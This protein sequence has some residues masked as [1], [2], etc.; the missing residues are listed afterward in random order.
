[1]ENSNGKQKVDVEVLTL[2]ELL[3]ALTPKQVLAILS[4]FGTLVAGTFALGLKWEAHLRSSEV[5]P[6]RASLEV[7]ETKTKKLEDDLHFLR[8]KEKILE[9]TATL[10]FQAMLLGKQ[11]SDLYPNGVQRFSI[12]EAE[13]G[14]HLEHYRHV[15]DEITNPSNGREPVADLRIPRAGPALLVFRNDSTP[16]VLVRTP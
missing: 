14:S 9:L 12:D 2:I 5:E 8:S 6:L 13:F 10:Q 3:H 4:L 15:I 11:L 1:M 16:W 7:A